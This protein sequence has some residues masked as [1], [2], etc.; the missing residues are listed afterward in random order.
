MSINWVV[1]VVPLSSKFKK[2]FDQIY[3]SSMEKQCGRKKVGEAQCGLRKSGHRI[4]S[5]FRLWVAVQH[6]QFQ[7]GEEVGETKR[8]GLV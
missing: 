5:G 6:R 8:N 1:L 2:S 7:T 3:V 4:L